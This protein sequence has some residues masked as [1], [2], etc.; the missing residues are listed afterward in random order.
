M[1]GLGVYKLVPL[2]R[3]EAQLV[4]LNVT[5]A[6]LERD[7]STMIS[8][9]ERLLEDAW[10]KYMDEDLTIRQLLRSVAHLCGPKGS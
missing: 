10:D 9:L 8:Q 5:A 3:R 4:E 2:L 1:A 6:D 7:L